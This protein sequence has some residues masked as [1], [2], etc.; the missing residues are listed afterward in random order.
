MAPLGLTVFTYP[1]QMPAPEQLVRQNIDGMLEAAG[2]LIQD[3]E[4]L[5]P[6][7]ALGSGS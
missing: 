3:M 4:T 5:N 7:A 2:R 1:S 6:G